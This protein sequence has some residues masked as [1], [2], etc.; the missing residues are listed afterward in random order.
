MTLLGQYTAD[1]MRYAGLGE[2][3]GEELRRMVWCQVSIPRRDK[4]WWKVGG[5]VQWH[6]IRDGAH[7][8][9]K[10]EDRGM[11][12]EGVGVCSG[13]VEWMV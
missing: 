7:A 3:R 11:T 1:D 2:I 12:E 8:L 6:G 13:G 9:C 4:E 10:V 5:S